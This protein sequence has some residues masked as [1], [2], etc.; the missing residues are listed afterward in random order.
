MPIKNF[1]FIFKEKYI[2]KQTNI[3]K[4][5]VIFNTLILV[6]RQANFNFN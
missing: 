4:L 1:N 3:N 2:D 5:L 6:L